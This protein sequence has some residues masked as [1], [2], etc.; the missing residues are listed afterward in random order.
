M[1]VT[2]PAPAASL[3]VGKILLGAVV[4][5]W[6][7]RQTL[8]PALAWPA[9]V[10]LVLWVGSVLLPPKTWPLAAQW[11]LAGVH[12][13]VLAWLAV[14]CHRVV[15]GAETDARPTHRWSGHEWKY[16]FYSL[17]V[18][19][20]AL[21]VLALAAMVSGTLLANLG[22][23]LQ[24]EHNGWWTMGTGLAAL[25]AGYVLGRSSLV[26]PAIALG[27][28]AN[29]E[30]AWRMSK[31][32]GWRLAVL[33]GLVPYLLHAADDWAYGD[34]ASRWLSTLFVPVSVWLI[35][36]EVVALSLCY[37]A[38]AMPP[39]PASPQGTGQ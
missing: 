11:L 24:H 29:L 8:V 7:M 19:L 34:T 10:L 39:I 6:R 3:E 4:L 28:K 38:L 26:L 30:G 16:L 21:L 36:V 13:V 32:H 15:L 20:M 37:R 23:A 5:P 22:Q 25:P 35:I 33:I 14:Q 1:R 12:S 9:A 27:V 17:A 2:D 31:G 18:M